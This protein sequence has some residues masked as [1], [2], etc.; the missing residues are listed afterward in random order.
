MDKKSSEL[1]RIA[2]EAR[3]WV[4]KREAMQA[5]ARENLIDVFA[6]MKPDVAAQQLAVMNE[7]SAASILGNLKP[8]VA[9]AI[10]NEMEAGRAARLADNAMRSQG[11][12]PTR[13]KSGS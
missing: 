13:E 6:K 9:S 11:A 5:A 3:A 1:S 10:L 2:R 8:R 4:E 12:V 7:D